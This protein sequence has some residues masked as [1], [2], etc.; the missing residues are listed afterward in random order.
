MKIMFIISVMNRFGKLVYIYIIFIFIILTGGS[1]ALG[2]MLAYTQNIK[3]S[4][5]FADFNPALPSR[6]LDIR[7]DLITEFSMDEKRDLINY[8]GISPSLIQA[9]LARE[10]R[11]FYE[12]G[13]FRI[14]SIIRAVIGQLT[15]HS[16]GGGS[17]ITQQ[18]A[19]LLYC[20][21]TDK[22][23]KRK[24]L[25]L[26]WALQMERRYSKDEIMMLYLNEV[27]FGSG[28]YG[29]S[30]ASRFYFGHSAANLTPAE[31][32]ILVIQLS[33][34]T[35]YNPFENPNRAKERQE[36]VLQGMVDLGYLTKQ[37]AT[38]SFEEYWSNFDYTR[39]ALSAWLTREDKARWFSEYVRRKLESMMYGTMNLYKDGYTVHTTCDLRHQE[40]AEAEFQK[41]LK[42]VNTRLSRSSSGSFDQTE[43]YGNIT[44]L[45][46]LCF[47]MEKLHLGEKQ[48]QV[49][50][51]AYYRN[52]LNNT[53]DVLSLMCGIDNLK[54]L[55]K[56]VTAKTQELLS[57][58]VVEGTF[59]SMETETGYI[60][61]IIGGSQYNEANQLIRATQSKL[62]VGSSIKPLI[63]SAAI[64]ARVITPAT[65]MDDTPQVF[66][67]ADGVQYVPNNYSG[68][69][70]GT[71]LVY[72]ALPLS[73]NIPAIKILEMVG[74]DAA[75]NRI[76][77]L[78]GIT[79]PIE[80][81]KTFE[82][83]YPMALGISA[84]TPVQLLRAFAIFGNQGKAV[85]P[86]AIRS[87]ENREGSTILD[88]EL[89]L[90]IEQRKLGSAMQVISP[91]NA[92]VMTQM[93]K[94]TMTLGTLYGASAA[95]KK[96][97]YKDSKTGKIFQM[98]MAAKTGTTQ[99]WSDSWAI[100][101]S[102][103]YSTV[104]WYGFDRGGLSLGTE[105]SGAVLSGYV[106][107]NFMREVHRGKPFKDFVAPE[108][109]VVTVEVCKKSGMLPSEHCSDGTVFLTLLSGTAPTEVCT[110]H[111]AG[112]RLKNIGIDRLKERGMQSGE[113]TIDIDPSPIS[114]DP[115]VFTDPADGE[116]A[117]DTENTEDSEEELSTEEEPEAGKTE[118]NGN[119]WM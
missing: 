74:F 16:L 27:Y 47:G 24:V 7:G 101:Y 61:A 59:L 17:T 78:T 84:I 66:E 35:K 52:N 64:D 50:T 15:G 26:W 8:G 77:A 42:D 86:I 14:K 4:E 19:G 25:E 45:L 12:H 98:P 37:E 80:I 82:R 46:S 95:G 38:D 68:K 6:I 92:Y 115:S 2:K 96:F 117:G 93:L 48:L 63:Y 57:E 94:K 87:V 39:I 76:S 5:L 70:K 100:I 22:S 18:I 1:F 89:D 91:Q 54:T 33:N 81:N 41:Y 105:S 88:P 23:V 11:V 85:E 36:N 9:L 71:V 118:E 107:V 110:E 103:Y 60:T 29:V 119:P 97:E 51:N 114:I 34:P 102:P 58:K 49:K 65:R 56:Q 113:E 31:A 90:R 44:A 83:V 10:D 69:W 3:Q 108:S 20:D 67:S 99:N 109:G 55:T 13:G 21:R 73:L 75:I 53:I 30:A 72:Q 32:A 104:V 112:M 106:A 40:I 79:D 43:K 116:K 111:T 28:T 62:K